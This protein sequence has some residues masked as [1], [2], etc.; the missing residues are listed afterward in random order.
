MACLVTVGIGVLLLQ[1]PL[2]HALLGASSSNGLGI[3]ITTTAITLLLI[4][5]VYFILGFLLYTTLFAAFGAMVK[6]QDEIQSAVQPL[7]WLFMVGYIVSAAAGSTSTNTIWMKTLSFIPFWTP[8][9]M[10]TRIGAGNVSWWEILVSILLMIVAILICAA[11]S[12]RVYRV[13]V[14]MYGQRPGLRQLVRIAR[15]K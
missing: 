15:M 6:R 7:T 13:S 14:L 10:L 2:Q 3:N 5:L 11:F 9:I 1:N 12:A 8:T 4:V